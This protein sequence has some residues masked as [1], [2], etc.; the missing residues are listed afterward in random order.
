MAT[1]L[2]IED[3]DH[4]REDIVEL[5]ESSGHKTLQAC[6]GKVALEM[7][8]ENS[9]DLVVSDITMPV[10]DGREL[11]VE[12]RKNYP[13]FACMPFIFLSALADREDVLDGMKLGADDYIT[14]P[15]DFEMLANK[16]E[17]SLRQIER[18]QALKEEQFVKLFNALSGNDG[19]EPV[20]APAVEAEQ[21]MKE[22][23]APA[24][25]ETEQPSTSEKNRKKIFGSVFQ[26]DNISSAEDQLGTHR[27]SI[28]DWLEEKACCFLS[29]VLPTRVS[30]TKIPSGGILVCYPDKDKNQA[31]EK[32]KQ[33]AMELEN[34]LQDDQLNELARKTSISRELL[35]HLA[36]VRETIYET[37]I[38]LEH[39]DDPDLFS[40]AIKEQIDKIHT[41]ES[42]PARLSASIKKNKGHLVQLTL[43]KQNRDTLP[44][45]FFNF[46]DESRKIIR[47]SFA[48]FGNV[49]LV[50]AG[51]LIDI[52]ALSLMEDA[53]RKVSQNE[54]VVIDVHYETLNSDK[55]IELY[56]PKF[57]KFINNTQHNVVMNIR[58]IPS[59]ITSLDLDD[60]LKP[61]G[62]HA[63]RHIVQIAPRM[64]ETLA[65]S[66]L[67][68]PS[69]VCSYSE[70]VRSGSD[71]SPF[72]KAKQKLSQAGILLVLRGLP[73]ENEITEFSNYG[74]DG[75]AVNRD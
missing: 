42:A 23:T 20:T 36:V 41:D 12:L 65:N 44:I 13:K 11:L 71:C 63:A 18:M 51:Y 21:E 64:I 73:S 32:S 30:V 10:M 27:K 33:L 1:I 25:D 9:P 45:K 57:M 62:K 54:T 6:N 2:C 59:S 22:E 34:H 66:G 31:N 50:K 75:F 7:I 14:K 61:F 8:V 70:L 38:G 49:N 5:M 28:L 69:I 68:V 4:I 3:E 40:A 56:L 48:L 74:F 24:A 26:F 29:K 37:D 43:I 55:Y 39:L 35:A 15:I 46:D 47:S 58:A 72:S 52:H 16:V 60:I 67:T 17:S 53:L 19:P